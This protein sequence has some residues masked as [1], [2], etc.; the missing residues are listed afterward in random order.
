MKPRLVPSVMTHVQH[1]S[2]HCDFLQV[3]C[4]EEQ[5]RFMPSVCLCNG[6]M[7]RGP[8]GAMAGAWQSF[9]VQQVLAKRSSFHRGLPEHAEQFWGLAIRSAC[10]NALSLSLSL[11]LLLSL[12]ML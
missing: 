9:L 3:A 5:Q 4:E 7:I 10:G 1:L 11:S 12:V 2:G 6:Q 8:P